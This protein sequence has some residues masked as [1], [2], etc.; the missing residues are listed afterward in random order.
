MTTKPQDKLQD[1]PKA[2]SAPRVNSLDQ[3]IIDQI[4]KGL[5]HPK[6]THTIQVRH[7][8]ENRYRVNVFVAGEC[9]TSR[10]AHS[11]FVSTNSEGVILES[12][13]AITPK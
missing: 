3:V 4:T 2:A 1:K 9:G 5:N 10:V 7:L 13:P 11:F 6:E 12:N 8:W